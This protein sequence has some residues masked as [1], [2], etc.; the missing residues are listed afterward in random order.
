[1][2][3][4]RKK[5]A[6]IKSNNGILSRKSNPYFNSDVKDD[7][8]DSGND[9]HQPSTL[10]SSSRRRSHEKFIKIP[11][12]SEVP[13]HNRILRVAI[14]SE[15]RA[16][17]HGDLT[18]VDAFSASQRIEMERLVSQLEKR[19]T[20]MEKIKTQFRTE[21]DRILVQINALKSQLKGINDQL[22]NTN[23]HISNIQAA[24]YR[25]YTRL[26][27]EQLPE[28]NVNREVEVINPTDE[29]LKL[30]DEEERDVDEEDELIPR[31]LRRLTR[32][33]H[34]RTERVP[35]L[36]PNSNVLEY[37]LVVPRFRVVKA[38]LEQ[39]ITSLDFPLLVRAGSSVYHERASF[40]CH[41]MY[42]LLKSMAT[43]LTKD[44]LDTPLL[45][46]HLFPVHEFSDK[47]KHLSHPL[48]DSYRDEQI[49]VGC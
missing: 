23:K 13:R 8:E 10:P 34:Q 18:D 5:I 7:E 25:N 21:R 41:T 39:K 40:L 15:R 36:P 6:K 45:I 38:I 1:M 3:N 12:L 47:Y 35:L 11:S 30:D 28:E 2:E 33:L 26:H 19:L 29:D 37:V 17:E 49:E 22:D 24:I 4:K 46:T 42:E 48:F 27:P 20:Q 31:E 9:D 16:R 14:R 44:P 32:I 43:Y